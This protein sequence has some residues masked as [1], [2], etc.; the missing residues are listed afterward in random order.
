MKVVSNHHLGVCST[1]PCQKIY[2]MPSGF[3]YVS[4]CTCT[5][6]VRVCTLLSYACPGCMRELEQEMQ[7]NNTLSCLYSAE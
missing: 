2:R 1:C 5:S 3:C 7:Q 4:C 6:L